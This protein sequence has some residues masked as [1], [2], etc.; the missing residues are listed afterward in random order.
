MS[1]DGHTPRD[2]L[3]TFLASAMTDPGGPFELHDF[4]RKLLEQ[5]D[6]P[7]EPRPFV[8]SPSYKRYLERVWA[9]AMYRVE[10][11]ERLR[12]KARTWLRERRRR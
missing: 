7:Y 11:R 10:T 9:Q 4:Q 12:V 1:D 2:D 3:P 6:K 5:F 8:V